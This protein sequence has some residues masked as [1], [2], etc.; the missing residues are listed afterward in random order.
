MSSA[1][2]EQL[3]RALDTKDAEEHIK[4]LEAPALGAALGV[5][6]TKEPL[7]IS[8]GLTLE[9]LP[10]YYLRRARSYCFIHEILDHAFGEQGLEQTQRLRAEGPVNLSL[11]EELRL[12]QAIFHGAYLQACG[13][14]GMTPEANS[15]LGDPG[16]ANGDRALLRTWLASLRKDPDLGKDIRMMI[17]IFY[18]LARRKTKVWVVLGIATN[19]LTMSYVTPP[20]YQT[21]RRTRR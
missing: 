2:L 13:E 5:Q 11:G 15:H 4:Q 18:D 3:G 1:K 9:P 14:I 12:M 10:T 7:C 21:G 19:P 16:G 6:T 20:H 17:P 8:A